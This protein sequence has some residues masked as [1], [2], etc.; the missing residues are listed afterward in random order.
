MALNAYFMDF[1]K[2]LG[3]FF[4]GGGERRLAEDSLTVAVFNG[5]GSIVVGYGESSRGKG[6]ALPV[7]FG[8]GAACG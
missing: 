3:S 2:L 8:D 5:G 1:Y 7:S 6:F 4:L